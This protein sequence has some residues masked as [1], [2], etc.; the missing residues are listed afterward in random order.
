MGL[1]SI[2]IFFSWIAIL[3]VGTAAITLSSFSLPLRYGYIAFIFLLLIIC[4]LPPSLKEYRHMADAF[5]IVVLVYFVPLARLVGH[6]ERAG[7]RIFYQ[8]FG[9]NSLVEMVAANSMSGII[10]WILLPIILVIIEGDRLK[11]IFIKVGKRRGWMVGGVI[12]LAFIIA[13][14]IAAFMSEIEMRVYFSLLPLAITFALINSIK[15]EILYRGLLFGRT[16]RFG[17]LFALVCQFL[18]FGLIH[19][20]YSGGTGWGF[21]G[22]LMGGVAGVILAWLT[23]KFESLACPILIHM[24]LDFVLFMAVMIPQFHSQGF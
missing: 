10:W 13:G 24:G 23:K 15:E 1:F 21:R 6:V 3:V 2:K 4:R 19:M 12:L 17:F 11:D 9:R 16:L 22:L 20:L 7:E 5:F 18:W 8:I 14:F